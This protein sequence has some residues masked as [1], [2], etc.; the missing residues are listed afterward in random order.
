MASSEPSRNPF[1]L[2]GQTALV[3]GGATGLGFGMARCFVAAGAR[4]VLVGRRE[5]ELKKAVARLGAQAKYVCHDV[6][7]V[8]E[9]DKLVETATRTA[10]AP[11]DILVN[12]AGVHLKKPAVE[13][14]PEEFLTVLNTHVIGAHALTRAVLPDMIQRR[15]G[16]ILFTASMAALFGLPKVIAYSAAKSAYVGMVRTLA[17]EVSMHNVRVNAIAPGWIDSD[18]MR[19]ALDGDS[20]RRDKILGRT[21]MN[22]F[23]DADDIGWAAVYLCSPAAK[24]VTGVVLPVDGGVSIGF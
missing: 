18:M 14:T 13:T 1:N 22:R 10:G 7:K 21:P 24:F 9:A 23:G 6:T 16:N 4:A 8:G 11:M 17:T 2:D 20:A 5:D 19:K 12:N 3:T 15:R